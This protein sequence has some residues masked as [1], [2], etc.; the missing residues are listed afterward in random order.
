[1]PRRASCSLRAGP[2]PGRTVGRCLQVV[3]CRHRRG[4][5][6]VGARHARGQRRWRPPAANWP[7][8]L[9]AN[10]IHPGRLIES[11][12]HRVHSDQR[13]GRH[14]SDRRLRL[15]VV[16][17][18]LVRILR[19]PSIALQAA[20]AIAG[21][22]ARRR[23]GILV[24]LQKRN[25]RRR[26]PGRRQFSSAASCRP[27]FAHGRQTHRSRLDCA[28]LAFLPDSSMRCRRSIADDSH[29]QYVPS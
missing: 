12:P 15:V 3:G 17:S 6:T 24:A 5:W 2:I 18:E 9:P 21:G 14:P 20:A 13:R 1:M 27:A 10:R 26:S 19:P 7:P 4:H 25:D 29:G 16:G 8:D 23:V 11:D 22:P 28:I